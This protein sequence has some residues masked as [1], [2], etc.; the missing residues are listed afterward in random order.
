MFDTL[1]LA[2]FQDSVQK[3]F[4]ATNLFRF[5]KVFVAVT[6]EQHSDKWRK[7]ST[8]SSIFVNYLDQIRQ[9]LKVYLSLIFFIENS[10]KTHSIQLILNSE[11]YRI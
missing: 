3:L 4:K 6:Q 8:C 9:K 10:F 2:K 11:I 7:K 1:C 5:C